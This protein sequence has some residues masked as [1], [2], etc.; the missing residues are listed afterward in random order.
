MCW[1]PIYDVKRAAVNYTYVA[2]LA[3]GELEFYISNVR[4]LLS[5]HLVGDRFPLLTCRIIGKLLQT[6]VYVGAGYVY[7]SGRIPSR[8]SVFNLKIYNNVISRTDLG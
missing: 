2:R 5:P 6:S 7:R 3:F 8:G 1:R 4:N